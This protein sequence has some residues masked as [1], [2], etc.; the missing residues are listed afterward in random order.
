MT[1]AATLSLPSGDLLAAT[2]EDL[3]ETNHEGDGPQYRPG[4]PFRDTLRGEGVQGVPF[5][6]EGRVLSTQA[7]ALSGAVLDIWQVD[8]T[9]TYD[10]KGWRTRGRL[11]ADAQGRYRLTTV[12]PVPY[13][14][15]AAHVHVKVSAPGFPLLTTA[16]YLEGDSTKDSMR[17]AALVVPLRAEGAGKAGRFDFVLKA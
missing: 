7:K 15:R 1:A 6:L 9:G 2:P 14:S 13:G 8:A 11:K 12:L 5:V 16:L 4:A 10:E 3:H 17:Q